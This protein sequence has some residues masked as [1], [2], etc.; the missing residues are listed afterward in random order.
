[1]KLHKFFIWLLLNLSISIAW[2]DTATLYQQFPPTAEGTGKVYMGREIAHVMGYQGAAWLERE[3]REKE[4]RTDLLIQSL[5]LKEG[6]TVADVGAGTGY[7]SRKMAARVGNTGIVYAVD[8]QPEMIGK[9][10][11]T[12]KQ[13]TN[14]K[15]VLSE[16]NN[17]NLPS[18]ILDLAIMVDVYHELAYPNEVM[19]SVLKALKPK[20]QLVLVEYRAED[21][22]V[23]IKATHK[24]SEV[25]IKAEM[26]ALPLSWQKTIKTLPWQ[27]VVVFT[28]E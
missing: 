20:G 16:V 1:M 24:M 18:N 3:N 9:L 19:Q 23:P 2:A 8:V 15:P 28:K 5:G 21:D 17:V 14:V 27:H 13:F 26:S 11:T 25:Q 4:E 12:A 22:R 10:K 7:L 6:M